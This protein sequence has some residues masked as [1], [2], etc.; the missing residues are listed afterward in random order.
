M[1]KISLLRYN[2]QVQSNVMDHNITCGFV[3]LHTLVLTYS[4]HCSFVIV[5]FSAALFWRGKIS[6]AS[7][8]YTY[9]IFN[10]ISAPAPISTPRLF[11]KNYGIFAPCKRTLFLYKQVDYHKKD[12]LKP[13]ITV[14]FKSN[15]NW[16]CLNT[17][18]LWLHNA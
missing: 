15:V 17:L 4:L 7:A 3:L 14:K 16:F 13:L 5:L 18:H 6:S 1:V 9:T 2:K 10:P 11:M 12:S 8:N